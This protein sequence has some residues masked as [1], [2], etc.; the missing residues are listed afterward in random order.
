MIS[1]FFLKIAFKV[2]RINVSNSITIEKLLDI[3]L[4]KV[5]FVKAYKISCLFIFISKSPLPDNR[6]GL[7]CIRCIKFELN[8]DKTN[9]QTTI[10][11][12]SYEGYL[13]L[14]KKNASQSLSWEEDWGDILKGRKKDRNQLETT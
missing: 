9:R 8:I 7:T 12:K 3:I 1:L 14:G 11:H 5:G 2:S 6:F 4:D 10:G 13:G